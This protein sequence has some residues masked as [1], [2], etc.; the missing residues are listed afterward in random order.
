MNMSQDTPWAQIPIRNW[1]EQIE[2]D[3]TTDEQRLLALKEV[4]QREPIA[5][6]GE[7]LEWVSQYPRNYHHFPLV[8]DIIIQR[9]TDENL[10]QIILKQVDSLQWY[11]NPY[12]GFLVYEL[13]HLIGGLPS[14]KI[15]ERLQC[16]K[17]TLLRS[18]E[19]NTSEL[20]DAIALCDPRYTLS[21][22]ELLN[23]LEG[24]NNNIPSWRASW[25][26]YLLAGIGLNSVKEINNSLKS[27]NKFYVST[28]LSALEHI[29]SPL[30]VEPLTPHLWCDDREIREHVIFL[31]RDLGGEKAVR[32]LYNYV[33]KQCWHIENR[34]IGDIIMALASLGNK[35]VEALDKLITHS[36]PKI[37]EALT[38][39]I[40]ILRWREEEFER[41]KNM[42]S[43]ASASDDVDFM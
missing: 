16:D 41:L 15:T 2:N 38:E 28:V 32:V 17:I 33:D 6:L 30:D 31:L 25:W 22:R 20:C 37:Y 40:E 1:I 34:E 29:R 12:I 11:K 4:F 23:A 36:C 9:A 42:F 26:S 39:K 43:S 3:N 18:I 10:K 27:K 8:R 5:E 21:T 14:E 19:Q 24:Y 7:I 35:G 13:I